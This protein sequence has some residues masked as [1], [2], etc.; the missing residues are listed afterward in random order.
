[1]IGYVHIFYSGKFH[2]DMSH[3]KVDRLWQRR[4]IASMLVAGA[5]LYAQSQQWSVK[6][7]RL[8]VIAKNFKAVEL[9]KSLGL[10]EPECADQAA[11]GSGDEDGSS[12]S[13]TEMQA[14]MASVGEQ[15]EFIRRCRERAEGAQARMNYA[16]QLGSPVPH[17]YVAP[18]M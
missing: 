10:C 7:I 5:C 14:P 13:W 1:M 18:V 8:V 12:M 11:T 17:A 2:L 9:Y 15:S 3:L 4:G 16:A 6:E